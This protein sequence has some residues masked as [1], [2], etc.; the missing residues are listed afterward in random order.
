V[1]FGM[2]R[3]GFVIRSV[4]PANIGKDMTSDVATLSRDINILVLIPSRLC[5]SSLVD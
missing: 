5:T 3:R 1:I 2:D 4:C